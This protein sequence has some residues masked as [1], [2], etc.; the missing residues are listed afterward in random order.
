MSDQYLYV[1]DTYNHKIKRVDVTANSIT[2]LTAKNSEDFI[3]NE[4][5]GLC[6]CDQQ[7]R[8]YIADTNN[9][10]I[11]I[12]QFAGEKVKEVSKFTLKTKEVSKPAHFDKKRYNILQMKNLKLNRNGGKIILGIKL[13]F[14]DC[15]KYNE[16]AP[17]KWSIVC[18]NELWGSAPNSGNEIT[19]IDTVI[20]APSCKEDSVFYIVYN[21]VICKGDKCIPKSLAVEFKVQFTERGPKQITENISIGT[22]TSD[23]ILK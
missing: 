13:V 1:A 2:T 17:Q 11:K 20:N 4:P 15:K 8:L 5:S 14:K 6:M 16:G 10:C 9:H 19:L 12:I 23:E 7:K 3:F 22:G 18:P 21:F